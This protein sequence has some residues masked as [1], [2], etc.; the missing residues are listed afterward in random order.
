M[1]VKHELKLRI[2]N[3]CGRISVAMGDEMSVSDQQKF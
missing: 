2:S 3:V 1:N